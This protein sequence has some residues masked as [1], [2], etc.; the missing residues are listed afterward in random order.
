MFSLGVSSLLLPSGTA[1]T[2]EPVLVELRTTTV[3]DKGIYNGTGRVWLQGTDSTNLA[4]NTDLLL[5]PNGGNVGIGTTGP[6]H[7]AISKRM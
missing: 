3:L 5:N 1:Q 7:Q 2:G 6:G 4:L